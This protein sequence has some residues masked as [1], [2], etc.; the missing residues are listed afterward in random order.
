MTF[1]SNATTLILFSDRHL[2]IISIVLSLIFSLVSIFRREL[3]S[4]TLI[5]E[6]LWPRAKPS[7]LALSGRV[8]TAHRAV[9][10]KASKLD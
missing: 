6:A 10:T 8:R 2:H 9:A 1:A 5:S 3:R 4:I 7:D